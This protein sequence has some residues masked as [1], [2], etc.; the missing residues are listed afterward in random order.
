MIA[1]LLSTE[2]AI[3][4]DVSWPQALVI[5]RDAFHVMS[6]LMAPKTST[7]AVRLHNAVSFKE[8]LKDSDSG[9]HVDWPN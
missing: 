1:T 4:K 7:V 9:Y 3:L 5:W 8:I 6:M 2:Q